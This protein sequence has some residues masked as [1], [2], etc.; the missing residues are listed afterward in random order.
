MEEGRNG[1]EG[2]EERMKGGGGW[3]EGR[4]EIGNAKEMGG[5]D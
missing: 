5:E 3:S 2:G 4:E 1:I